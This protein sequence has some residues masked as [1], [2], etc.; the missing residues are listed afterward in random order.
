MKVK[1]VFLILALVVFVVCF[2]VAGKKT[3]VNTVSVAMGYVAGEDIY[4]HVGEMY[5]EQKAG[6][7][8]SLFTR[9]NNKGIFN[10]TVLYAE[11]GEVVYQGAFGWE[12]FRRRDTMKVDGAFQ[13]ASVSKMFTAMAIMI[14]EERGK[15]NYDDYITRFIPEFP[16]EGVTIRQLLNHRSGLSRYMSLADKNWNISTPICNEDVIDLFVKYQPAPYFKP[17]DGFHYCNT[18]YALLAC[19]VERISKQHFDEFAKENIFDPIEMTHS[20]V[21]NLRGDSA[22]SYEIPVGVPGYRYRGRRLVKVGDYYLN[23]VM[24]DKGV[25]STVDDLFKFNKALDEEL[26][27]SQKTLQQAFSPGSPK[28]YKRKDNYGF[29]WRIREEMDSTAYHF[30]WWK[31]FRTYYIRDMK[32]NRV[33]IAL[34]N[35]HKGVSSGVLWDCIKQENHTEDLLKI[36][37]GL[38]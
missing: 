28:Y 35:T 4:Y 32:N 29:G 18:N 19:V 2:F 21:Y 24:G 12:D 31:G 22:I 8:E 13:L 36:Y 3:T 26:L 17:D 10:G 33:L 15:L 6:E 7:I 27:V 5:S 23:G 16:Y 37:Q 38:N 25:Y 1:N 20:F 11:N 9:L 30:G 34:T 14:L